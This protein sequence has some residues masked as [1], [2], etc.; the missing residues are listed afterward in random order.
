MADVIEVDAARI[1]HHH[2]VGKRSLVAAGS[3]SGGTHP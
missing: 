1:A 3:A 2:R